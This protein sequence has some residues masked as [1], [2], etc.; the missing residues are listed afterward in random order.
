MKTELTDEA[1]VLPSGTSSGT[2]GCIVLVR[3][4]KLLFVSP[5]P[6][7]LLQAMLLF[8]VFLGG[9]LHGLG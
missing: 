6:A 3:G 4:K 7:E 2:V 8:C 1:K 9:M 5:A